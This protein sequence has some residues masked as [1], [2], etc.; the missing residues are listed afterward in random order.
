M[1]SDAVVNRVYERL[2]VCVLIVV[3]I[4]ACGAMGGDDELTCPEVTRTVLDCGVEVVVYAR[5]DLVGETQVWVRLHHG[6]MHELDHERGASVLASRA[7]VLGV[8]GISGDR[9]SDMLG[10]QPD[11][12]VIGERVRVGL[13]HIEFPFEVGDP[14]LSSDLDSDLGSE[15]S[16][17]RDAMRVGR[18]LVDGYVPSDEAIDRAREGVLGEVDRIDEEEVDRSLMRRW[19][20]ELVGGSG[21]GKL[22]IPSRDVVAGISGDAVRGSVERLWSADRASVLVV[23]DVDADEVIGLAR[24]VF[25]GCDGERHGHREDP[26]PIVFEEGLGGRVV[27]LGDE[28]VGLSRIGLVWFGQTHEP[29]WDDAGV[30]DL[31]VMALV[32]ES[33]RHRVSLMLGAELSN[34]EQVRVDAGDLL[35]RARY[36][37]IVAVFDHGSGEV[38]EQDWGRVIRAMERE[39]VRLVRDGVSASEIERAREWLIQQWGYEVDQWKGSTTDE[40]ARSLSWMMMMD[41]PLVE[42]EDWVD[43]ARGMLDGVGRDEI[44]DVIRAMFYGE[45]AVLVLLDTEDAADEADIR[46]ALMSARADELPAL[47]EGWI[48]ELSGP[49]L[50]RTGG[51]VG[52]RGSRDDFSGEV[53]E[54]SLHPASG[55]VSAKLGNG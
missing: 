5:D 10:T 2:M 7:A 21:Y 22:P 43:W 48:D 31:L 27:T 51:R 30:Q 44:H 39:R 54:I 1:W 34:I 16:K 19:I 25:D 38:A 50:E 29:R 9:I 17:M 12:G 8:G 36:G 55:V 20:P 24:E 14:G 15:W 26:F 4:I 49:I 33:M 47:A 37:Q 11:R 35:G 6:S 46:S 3:G 45:P 32:G 52:P 18:A 23:G 28:R 13:G 41:R 42:L 53:D 40:L